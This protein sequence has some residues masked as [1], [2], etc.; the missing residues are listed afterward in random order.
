MPSK[1]IAPILFLSLATL[2]SAGQVPKE[3]QETYKGLGAAMASMKFPAVADFFASEFFVIDS[4]GKS[5]A[6]DPFL[7][8]IAG[9]FEGMTTAEPNAKLISATTRKGV[10]A[11]KFEFTLKLSNPAEQSSLTAHEVGTDYWK[12]SGG[13]WRMIKTVQK[14]FEVTAVK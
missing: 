13:K 8:N 10:V 1:L 2:A 12:K 14:S 4:K 6:R 5:M 7:K 11:V 9:L 3:I